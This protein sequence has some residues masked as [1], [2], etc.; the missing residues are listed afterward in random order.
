MKNLA[1]QGAGLSK[2][3]ADVLVDVIE[4]G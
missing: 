2:W 1:V 4:G 3:E